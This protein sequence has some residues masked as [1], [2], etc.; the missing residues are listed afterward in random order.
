MCGKLAEEVLEKYKVEEFKKSAFKR[1]GEPPEWGIVRGDKRYQLQ[2]WSEEYWARLYLWFREYSLQRH[3]RMQAG[4]T[5]E[6]GIKQQKRMKIV[7]D[8]IR[9]IKAKGSMDANNSWWVS[10][11]LAAACKKKAWLHHEWE[12]TLQQWHT[13]FSAAHWG[14]VNASSRLNR[15]TSFITHL[16]SL[17]RILALSHVPRRRRH[18]R[19]GRCSYLGGGQ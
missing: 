3:K 16:A 2:K 5:E 19:S 1:P 11:L 18:G 6:E 13:V 9:R 17:G 14:S 8:M 7:T 12:D 4:E 15:A 10:E